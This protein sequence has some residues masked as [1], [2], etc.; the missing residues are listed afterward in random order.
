MIWDLWIVS[1]PR[2]LSSCLMRMTEAVGFIPFHDVSIPNI[3]LANLGH[4][5]NPYGFYE[6]LTAY[7]LP[8]ETFQDVDGTGRSA[9]VF[10]KNV[11]ILLDA[12]IVP[13]KVI[14]PRRDMVS[15]LESWN[16]HFPKVLPEPEKMLY[17]LKR[18]HERL[19]ARNIP[20]HEFLVDDMKASPLQECFK[21]AKFLDLDPSAAQVMANL[22]EPDLM[23]F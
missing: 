13:K 14:L 16:K 15:I 11:P 9:K 5:A 8:I 22:F 17:N 20:T 18:A 1:L 23:H 10:A 12:N 21:I 19:N 6:K 7:D 4:P 2:S 3:A